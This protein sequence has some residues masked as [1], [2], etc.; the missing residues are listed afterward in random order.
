[1]TISRNILIL[2][3]GFGLG[4]FIPGLLIRNKLRRLGVAADVVVFES[5]L[6]PTKLDMVERN[7]KAYH[8]NFLVALTSAKVPMD[9]SKSLDMSAVES[10]FLDWERRNVRD[11]ICISGHWVNILDRYRKNRP[12][13]TIRGDLL[14]LDVERPPSWKWL[15]KSRPDYANGYR[16]FRLYDSAAMQCR[17]AIDVS[18]G[19]LLPWEMR[20]RRLV[21]HG[22]GWGMGTFQQC[23]PELAN[24]GFA[25]DLLCYARSEV[26]A[27]SSMSRC[28]M[29]DPMWRTWHTDAGGDHQFPPF[30]QVGIEA[31]VF[32]RQQECHGGYR[33]IRHAMGVMSKA[34]AGTL[35][36][37]FGSATPLIF[38][39]P[40]GP[41]EL[42]NS[43]LWKKSGFGVSYEVWAAAGFPVAMLEQLH[44]NLVTRREQVKDY[45]QEYFDTLQQLD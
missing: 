37:S 16:E 43:Q 18:A 24:S 20:E 33:L 28:F 25:L 6:L 32:A 10:L 15:H 27:N 4:H 21:V 29:D 2:C 39:D 8:E 34:G 9:S 19:P 17:Y 11:F 26:T 44:G 3:S 40:F 31:P 45:V 41:H 22:G 38:L 12:T 5:L 14:Y 1:M 13:T 42:L 35:I 23:I 7:R 36:D 30:G